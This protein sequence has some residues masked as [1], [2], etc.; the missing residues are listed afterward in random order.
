MPSGIASTDAASATGVASDTSWISNLAAYNN[1]TLQAPALPDP[2]PSLDFGIQ[3]LN[4]AQDVT[5][6]PV[7][8]KGSFM[9]FSIE[10]SVV[11][12]VSECYISR[13]PNLRT[14]SNDHFPTR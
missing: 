1:V 6:L 11:D 14:Q 8:Q 13:S 7:P 9:G 4:N 10:M 3:L 5:G 12:Q 2:M